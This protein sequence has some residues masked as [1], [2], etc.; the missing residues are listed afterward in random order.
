MVKQQF[1][2]N[3]NVQERLFARELNIT[4]NESNL[5]IVNTNGLI[6]NRY[7]QCIDKVIKFDMNKCSNNQKKTIT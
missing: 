5:N 6:Q 3:K 1:Q 4:K 7:M 2:R